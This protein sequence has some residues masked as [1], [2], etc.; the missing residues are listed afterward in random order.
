MLSSCRTH[1]RRKSRVPLAAL[2]A[3]AILSDMT[4]TLANPAEDCGKGGE[5]AIAACSELIDKDPNDG[6]AY[7]NRGKAYFDKADN[8]RAIADFSEAIA[9]DPTDAKAYFNRGNVYLKM[10]KGTDAAA[11]FQQALT[12]DPDYADAKAA[13]E[14]ATADLKGG[15]PATT[16]A[17][18]PETQ[19]SVDDKNSALSALDGSCANCGETPDG[20]SP[21]PPLTP[22][23]PSGRM[24][25]IPSLP[26]ESGPGTARA[27]LAPAPESESGTM[28]LPLP[29]GVYRLLGTNDDSSAYFGIVALTQENDKVKIACWDGKKVMR[30]TGTYA[31]DSF[32]LKWKDGI[33]VTFTAG[34]DGTL[35]GESTD[36]AIIE[37]LEL[38]AI[39]APKDVSLAEGAYLVAGKIDDKTYEGTADIAK[40]KKGYRVAWKIPP[41]SYEG[42]G[43][44]VDNILT[45]TWGSSTPAVYALAPD[46]SLVGLWDKGFGEETLVPE[47]PDLIDQ[48]SAELPRGSDPDRKNC[49]KYVAM[50][51]A[52]PACER[53]IASGKYSG[54][55]LAVLY[56][57]RGTVYAF[58]KEDELAI[59]DFS[60][61]IEIDPNFRSAYRNRA[62]VYETLSR[63]GG[64]IDDYNKVVELKPDD[65]QSKRALKRIG[66]D[67]RNMRMQ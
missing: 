25:F 7:L 9:I 46:G 14:K 66:P 42:S 58:K 59:A 8:A 20:P 54:R 56:N 32:V 38:F 48:S 61:A 34:D 60:R 29:T 4:A 2:V 26:D 62:R 5:A 1:R 51:V 13:L 21:L 63:I 52:I 45:V 11:D 35:E 36:G 55:Q 43:T 27:P 6:A 40:T 44:L 31:G 3:A 17:P 24:D 39:A 50:E 23:K 33:R 65:A 12:L 49:K 30:G 28:P 15:S 22:S 64:A 10:D 16:S 37:T 53:A 47:N 19:A 41:T 57:N 67:I 18:Q